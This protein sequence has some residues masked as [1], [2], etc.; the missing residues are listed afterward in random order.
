MLVLRLFASVGISVEGRLSFTLASS[1]DEFLGGLELG[2]STVC[3]SSFASSLR[4]AFVV[5]VSLEGKPPLSDAK[6]L[7]SLFQL[8][9]FPVRLL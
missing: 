8:L 6:G 3:A 2:R 4:G 1:A 7:L 9:R 5:P